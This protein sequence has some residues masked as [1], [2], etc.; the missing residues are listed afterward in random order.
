ML[1]VDD[2]D[3]GGVGA[4]N[5]RKSACSQDP[6]VLPVPL[7]KP[8]DQLIGHGAVAL[9]DSGLHALTGVPSEKGFGTLRYGKALGQ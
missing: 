5:F 3:M 1:R 7:L 8:Q 4:N 9:Q 2:V 6:E